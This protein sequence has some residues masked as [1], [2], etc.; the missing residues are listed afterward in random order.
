MNRS[1]RLRNACIFSLI[2]L[3]MLCPSHLTADQTLSVNEQKQQVLISHV[4]ESIEKAK[5]GISKLYQGILNI[6]GMSGSKIRHFLNNVCSFKGVNYLEI[7]CWKGSTLVSAAYN[8]ETNFN[9]VPL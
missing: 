9:S 3:K 6:E 5:N 2:F 1:N 7:G 8:N 4:K